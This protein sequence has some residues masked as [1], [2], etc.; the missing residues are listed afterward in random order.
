MNSATSNGAGDSQV[1]KTITNGHR[2]NVSA[3]S[4]HF[5][6]PGIVAD[7]EHDSAMGDLSQKEDGTTDPLPARHKLSESQRVRSSLDS[8]VGGSI[9]QESMDLDEHDESFRAN[10]PMQLEKMCEMCEDDPLQPAAEGGD[11]PDFESVVSQ[12]V[13]GFYS[14]LVEVIS[15]QVTVDHLASD[16]YSQSLIE[17][18]ICSEA[19]MQGIPEETKTRKVLD[20][21][22]SKLRMSI[23]VKPF[24]LFV[25]VLNSYPSCCDLV[26]Q[27]KAAVYQ[28]LQQSSEV[29]ASGNCN[30]H[31]TKEEMVCPGSSIVSAV[32][33]LQH[34]GGLQSLGGE[35][36]PN[37]SPS[38]TIESSDGHHQGQKRSVFS[39]LRQRSLSSGAESDVSMTEEEIHQGLKKWQRDGKR[40]A[41]GIQKYMDRQQEAANTME[42][43]VHRLESTV[44]DLQTQVEEYTK[45]MERCNDEK[46]VLEGQL[47]IARRKILQLNREV[48]DLKR[49]PCN[50]MCE[51]KAKCEK[52]EK[53]IKRLEEEKLDYAAKIENLTQQR[54]LL[55]N[56]Y[57]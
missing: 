43:I 39:I 37:P 9:S 57:V 23:N 17:N 47:V 16:L 12:A 31:Y 21:V 29:S 18:A 1:L 42:E 5:D 22:M 52:L 36:Q 46:Q 55:L 26:V 15:N 7:S 24:N 40:L 6:M 8:G 35:K 4:G 27:M 14:S 10:S 11:C 32:T 3:D 25:E 54:D 38:G 50:G 2:R 34:Q 53:E 19:R 20:A 49:H 48:I 56:G 41:R 44:E 45:K 28:Q 33:V 30:T 51:H 13:R